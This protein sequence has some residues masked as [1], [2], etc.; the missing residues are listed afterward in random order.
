MRRLLI[1]LMLSSAF[2]AN[3][4]STQAELETRLLHKPLYLRGVYRD[5]KLSFDSAGKLESPSALT[6]FTLSGVEITKLSV[7]SSRLHLQGRRI[8]L[9]FAADVP[10]R[11]PIRVRT[12]F[13]SSNSDESMAIEVRMPHGGDLSPAL[14]AIFTESLAD[15]VPMMPIEWQTYAQ[16]HF[17][18][19]TD[20]SSVR[21]VSSTAI[22]PANSAMPAKHLPPPGIRAIG[23]GV[24]P[25]IVLKS[26]EPQFSQAARG[27]Q[28]AGNVLVYLQV[29]E[30]GQPVHVR[31]LHP[32]GLGLDESALVAVKG[33][34]FK[35]AM[36]DGRPVAIEMN[37]DVNFR[38]F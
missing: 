36:E 30:Q 17:S 13:F 24:T 31:L 27:A 26:I 3:A 8:A 23:D 4:Q 25:P 5:D 6:T 9:Q 11:V 32:L 12:S 29:N 2:V 38:I 7:G 33:Y 34:K 18:A 35:P 1:L 14:D 15:L 21:S 28:V 20:Q 10:Q 37:V 19:Q 16:E 22:E